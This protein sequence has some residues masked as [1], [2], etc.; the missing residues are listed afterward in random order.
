MALAEK[1]DDKNWRDPL[2][3]WTKSDA[4]IILR[5]L[6]QDREKCERLLEQ[7]EINSLRRLQQTALDYESMNR[8]QTMNLMN[9]IRF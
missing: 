4:E 6:K 8:W 5:K 9:R 3:G 1:I 7:Q 2:T